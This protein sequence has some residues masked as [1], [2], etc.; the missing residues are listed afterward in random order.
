MTPNSFL[1][2]LQSAENRTRSM[3]APLSRVWYMVKPLNLKASVAVLN[4]VAA[5][6]EIEIP[7]FLLRISR[8]ECGQDLVGPLK[9]ALVHDNGPI[10]DSSLG[11]YSRFVSCDHDRPTWEKWHKR[12]D[13][14]LLS[15]FQQL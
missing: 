3:L 15:Q 10:E 1:D 8:L 9:P 12:W 14:I 7:D 5:G 11:K 13:K 4:N 2:F 6:R